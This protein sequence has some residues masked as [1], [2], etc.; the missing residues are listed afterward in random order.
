MNKETRVH[1]H[2]GILLSHKKG[3]L[4]IFATEW[5]Q[6]ES[7]MFSEISQAQKGK[8]HMFSEYKAHTHIYILTIQGRLSYGEVLR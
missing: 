3:N 8:Y 4:P 6:L 1:L 5:F 2:H 7:I